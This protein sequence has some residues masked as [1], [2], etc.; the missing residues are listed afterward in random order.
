MYKE[1][2][3]G[4]PISEIVS[5]TG[6]SRKTWNKRFERYEK[7]LQLATKHDPKPASGD[8]CSMVGVNVGEKARESN[9]K[10]RT[11]V[12]NTTGNPNRQNKWLAIL[13]LFAVALAGYL[14]YMEIRKRKQEKS[15]YDYRNGEVIT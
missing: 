3:N 5:K 11:N 2:N 1:Y 10:A 7:Q 6:I 15:N 4:T 14:I 9:E 12:D 8:N 13:S